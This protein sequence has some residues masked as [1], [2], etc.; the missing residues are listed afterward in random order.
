MGPAVVTA[1]LLVATLSC[2]RPPPGGTPDTGAPMSIASSIQRHSAELLE[3]PGVVGVAEGARDGQPVVQI[4][5]ERRTPALLARLP[6][7]L[8]GHPVVVVETGEI[9]AQDSASR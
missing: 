7:A 8:D 6:R 5:V 9:R 4:L 3:L 2:H 1:G